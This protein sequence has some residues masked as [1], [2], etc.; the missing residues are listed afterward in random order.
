MSSFALDLQAFGAKTADRMNLV[1]RKVGLDILTGIVELT[2]VR[3]GRARAN[4]QT[5]IGSPAEGEVVSY[6]AGGA[7]GQAIASG[8]DAISKAEGDITI[9]LTNNVPYIER[10]E[11][12]WS[13]QA[14]NGMV[15]QTIARFP[16][17]VEEACG[18]PSLSQMP[19]SSE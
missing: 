8:A 7:A 19:R 5:T 3:T 17:L 15:R 9:F 13:Q 11:N 2:P 4:W 12:G 18:D 1:M 14:P 6:D 16:Y 10:L